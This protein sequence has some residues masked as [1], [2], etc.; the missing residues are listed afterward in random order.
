MNLLIGRAGDGLLLGEGKQYVR[1]ALLQEP[2][3]E[4]I[5]RITPKFKFGSNKQIIEFT[6]IVKP[7]DSDA[8]EPLNLVYDYF[9]TGE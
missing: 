7:I 6:I 4:E 5:I 3:I 8:I 9:I 1:E 2:R